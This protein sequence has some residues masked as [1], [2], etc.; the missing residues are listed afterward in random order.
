MKHLKKFEKYVNLEKLID[1]TKIKKYVIT[2]YNGV[3]FLDEILELNKKDV[4]K[5][6]L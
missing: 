1:L 2:E 6:N 3:Y 4:K 5:Y